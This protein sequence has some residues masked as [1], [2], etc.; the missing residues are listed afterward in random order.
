M[1]TSKDLFIIVPNDGL[2]TKLFCDGRSLNEKRH[3]FVKGNIWIIPQHYNSKP[4]QVCDCFIALSSPFKE[5]NSTDLCR[6]VVDSKDLSDLL[7]SMGGRQIGG[8]V[9]RVA[10]A[11]A[12][13]FSSEIPNF[14][15]LVSTRTLTPS[16]YTGITY[17]D[18]PLVVSSLLSIDSTLEDIDVYDYLQVDPSESELLMLDKDLF[19]AF[20]ISPKSK[21]LTDRSNFLRR[22]KDPVYWLYVILIMITIIQLIEGVYLFTRRSKK[23]IANLIVIG[24]LSLYYYSDPLYATIEIEYISEIALTLPT[25]Y[26]SQS[27]LTL[28]GMSGYNPQMVG[29]ADRNGIYTD[30]IIPKSILINFLSWLKLCNKVGLQFILNSV[31]LSTD[32]VYSA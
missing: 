28:F 1:S 6:E 30:P 16:A 10:S 4:Q 9:S 29:Y 8:E 22:H 31:Q 14:D 17:R 15:I 32:Q 5:I 11:F 24:V 20:S 27:A 25:L 2:D 18:F 13:R 7:S 12:W 19:K 21:I 23:N 3:Q 26:I